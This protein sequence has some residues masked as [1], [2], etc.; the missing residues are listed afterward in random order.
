MATIQQNFGRKTTNSRV[1]SSG[2]PLNVKGQSSQKITNLIAA[3]STFTVVAPG[4]SFYLMVSTNTLSIKPSGGVANNYKQGT[5]LDVGRENSFSMLEIKNNNAVSVVFQIFVGFDGYID[6]QLVLASD[7]TNVI[8]PTYPVASAAASLAIT[9]RSGQAFVDINGL[10][11]FAVKRVAIL[12]GNPD[13]GVTFNLQKQGAT[14]AN[15]NAVLPVY[16][17]TSLNLPI[18]GNYSLHVGGGN[19]NAIVSEIY[20]SLP[21][22]S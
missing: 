8:Y 21:A 18:A 7:T 4:T 16:P 17:L 9:D 13:S 2:I 14:A 11:F 19:I 12:I 15:G 6:N 20:E 5:G 22:L 3:G 1:N 10:S